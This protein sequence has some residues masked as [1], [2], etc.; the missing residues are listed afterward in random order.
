MEGYS[1]LATKLQRRTNILN[2]VM[3]KINN[4]AAYKVILKREGILATTKMR[5]PMENLTTEQEKEL[6]D[7]LDTLKFKEVII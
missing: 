4:I 7:T 6:L 3:C 2:G 1:E 5:R